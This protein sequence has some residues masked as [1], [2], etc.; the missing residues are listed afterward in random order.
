MRLSPIT[1]FEQ[2]KFAFDAAIGRPRKANAAL[3]PGGI[4]PPALLEAAIEEL[5]PTAS[6]IRRSLVLPFGKTRALSGISNVLLGIYV[7][8]P[9]E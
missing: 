2:N 3:L 5:P 9:F 4:E 6:A 1:E 8:E 7:A